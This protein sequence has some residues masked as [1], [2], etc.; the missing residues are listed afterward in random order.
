MSEE[1]IIDGVNVAGCK[2]CDV[3]KYDYPTEGLDVEC[4]ADYQN[5]MV[6]NCKGKTTCYFKQLKRLEKENEELK[7]LRL[8]RY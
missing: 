3:I 2:Y 4:Y 1:I 6:A 5:E 8:M 7:K